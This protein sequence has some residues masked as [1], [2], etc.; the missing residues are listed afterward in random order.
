[1]GES[2]NIGNGRKVLV[3]DDSMDIRRMLQF[4]LEDSGWEFIEAANG[5]E[6]IES[7]LVE[8]PDLLILDVMMPEINGWEVI[9]YVRE[10]DMIAGTPVVM[11]TGIGQSL[12]AMTSP[13]I[14]ADAYL[15]KPVDLDVLDEKI[16]EALAASATRRSQATV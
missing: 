10:K 9:K 14:G 15:D 3:A 8:Q 2:K 4:H 6:A 11:L 7:L 5:A 12:N 16:E 1:M 13:M